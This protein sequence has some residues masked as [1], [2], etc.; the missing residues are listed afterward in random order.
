MIRPPPPP[1][2]EFELLVVLAVA[3]LG[4]AAYPLAIRDEIEARTGRAASRAAVFITLERL[5]EKALLRSRYG[6][7]TPV[8]GGR[9]KRF[10]TLTADGLKAMRH[11]IDSVTALADGLEPLL[12]KR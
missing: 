12:R 6:Q 7:P 1:L 3:R 10:F 8:R 4:D 5:E 9:A 2:G 11:S